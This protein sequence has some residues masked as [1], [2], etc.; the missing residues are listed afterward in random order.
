MKFLKIFESF[1]NYPYKSIKEDEDHIY[2]DPYDL[3]TE[4]ANM[5]S[6]KN[7]SEFYFNIVKDNDIYKIKISELLDYVGLSLIK[8]NKLIIISFLKNLFLS[9]LVEVK[10]IYKNVMYGVVTDIFLTDNFDININIAN[11]NRYWIEVNRN[12][13]IDLHQINVDKFRNKIEKFKLE[14]TAKKFGL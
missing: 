7:V 4:M 8:E 3:A 12:E 2:V 1:K 6:V 9:E 14:L 10:T 13:Y 5:D 11:G